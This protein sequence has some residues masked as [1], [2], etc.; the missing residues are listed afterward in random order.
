MINVIGG[1]L[2]GSE[3]SWQ[4]ANLG[5]K[6]NLYEMRKANKTSF[7]HQTDNLAE[8]VCSNSLRADNL[9]S[10]I[11]LLHEEMRQCKSLIIESADKNKIPAGGALAVDRESFSEYI[12]QKIYNHKNINVINQEINSFDDFTTD[13]I[14]IVATGPLTSD[15]LAQNIIS[16]TG[17]KEL[18]FFDSIAPIIYKDSIDFSKAWYQSRYDNNSEENSE[19]DYINCPLTEE[20]YTTLIND[21]IEAEKTEFKSWE[22]DT[23]YFEGCLPIEVM[24][25]RGFKTLSFGPLKPV[26]LTNPHSSEKPYA[27]VQLRQDNKS[28]TLY[29]MVGFQTKMKY[30][31]QLRVFKKIPGLENATFA[32][33]GGIHRNIFI[34]SPKLLSDNLSLNNHNNIKFAGQITG[35]E[36]Y[37]ESAASGLVTAIITALQYYKKDIILPPNNTA[38]GA[39]IHY[40][41]KGHLNNND[42]QPMN[43]NFGLFPPIEK[44]IKDK[45]KKKEFIC[46]NAIMQI[47]NW[48]KNILENFNEYS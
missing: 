24:A 33:M 12:E 41:T 11:G 45:K 17:E 47:K 32:R 39:L 43:I 6:V 27:V 23:P 31:E 19:G 29:N 16:I 36:G 48:Y 5:I 15:Q 26:G 8:L 7:A 18:N 10:A 2:A 21:L 1:G 34:N 20:Q 13:S 42:F 44:K 35:V 25:E 9:Y 28:A 37:V 14:I 3:I 4:L 46:D 38:M 30:N 40:I 22:K